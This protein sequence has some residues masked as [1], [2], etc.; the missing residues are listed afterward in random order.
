LFI[1]SHCH[2]SDSQFDADREEVIRRAQ[3]RGVKLLLAIPEGDAP[4][5]LASPVSLAECHDGIYAAVGIHPHEARR[6]EPRHF[7]Q[8]QAAAA[9]PKVL[10][11]GEIGL[12]FHY[13]HS[14]R[15]TQKE[16]LIRQLE[17]AREV[18]R[19][20][21]IHCRDAWQ[22]LAEIVGCHGRASGLGGILHCFSGTPQDAFRFLDWGFLISF[23]GNITFK[24]ADD[25]RAVA[26]DIPLDR[27]LTETDSPYL[28]PVPHRGKRNEP[29]FVLEVAH[30]LAALREIEPEEFGRRVTENFQSFFH[31][32][33]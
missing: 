23:A 9:A 27:L 7:D 11:I 20:V 32:M 16:V 10:A 30:A 26:R 12:D 15:D 33:P 19:P 5:E 6:V 18:K 31:L 29:A 17:I 4:D 1:D 13:D 3:A 21:V 24:K 25:L 8:L 28:A 14:T 2:L 22:D